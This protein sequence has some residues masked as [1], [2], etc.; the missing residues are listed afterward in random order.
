MNIIRL[1]I[2]PGTQ[3]ATQQLDKNNNTERNRKTIHRIAFLPGT[4]LIWLKGAT[5]N[6]P[7]GLWGT[8]A[9]ERCCRCRVGKERTVDVSAAVKVNRR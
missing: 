9:S 5:I 7:C 6:D 1:C 3:P 4:T 2:G 8:K